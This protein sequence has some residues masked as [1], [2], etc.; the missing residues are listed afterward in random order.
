MTFREGV[1]C[2]GQKNIGRFVFLEEDEEKFEKLGS[3]ADNQSKI[4]RRILESGRSFRVGS[5]NQLTP[6]P[7]RRGVKP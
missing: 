3:V 2:C 5:R 6:P 7:K 1:I 4:N